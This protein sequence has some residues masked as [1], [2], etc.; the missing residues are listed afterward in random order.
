MASKSETKI[1]R[2]GA[3]KT[4]LRAGSPASVK[5]DAPF[6]LQIAGALKD[7]IVNGIYPVGAQLPTED[8]LSARFSVSRH[9][10]REALRRLRDDGLVASRQ[11]AGTVVVPPRSTDSY[12]HSV[13]S[14]NDLV[15]FAVS[16]RFAVESIK[17]AM[18][19]RSLALRAGI[20]GGNEWLVVCGYRYADDSEFP[21][22][23]TE[24][25]INR[26][27]AAVGRILQRHSGPIF[28]LIEDMFGQKIVEVDQEIA[29]TL[30]SP[31]LAAGLKV[32]PATAALEVRDTYKTASGKIAQ[33]TLSTLP[34]SRFRHSV[35]LRRVKG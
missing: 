13:N 18:I 34:A 2:S 4:S 14:I 7:E 35:T 24:Y 32:E 25:Y 26:D 28:P 12:V 8:E 9:T 19:D 16:T 21:I 31:A 30:V 17:M 27:F 5:S 6:Y 29:A 20:P 1:R 15:S 3:S 22:C 10:I 11:G 33:V 23:W